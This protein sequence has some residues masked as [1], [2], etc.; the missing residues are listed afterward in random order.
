[1]QELWTASVTLNY[2][3]LAIKPPDGC[4]WFWIGDH[5]TYDSLISQKRNSRTRV[6]CVRY[7]FA[8]GGKKD[9]QRA[10]RTGQ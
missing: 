1:V 7:T 10:F 5:E 4:L 6:Y 3:A 2:R 9:R 8:D